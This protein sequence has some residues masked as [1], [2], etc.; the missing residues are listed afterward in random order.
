MENEMERQATYLFS[1]ELCC[2]CVHCLEDCS[3]ED[4][5][6]SCLHSSKHWIQKQLKQKQMGG[7]ALHLIFNR[8]PPFNCCLSVV[9]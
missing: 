5:G 7:L 1:F 3:H 8:F 9:L 2:F 6:L 4:D